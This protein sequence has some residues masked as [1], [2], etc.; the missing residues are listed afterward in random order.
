M[1]IFNVEIANQYLL[2]Q[3]QQWKQLRESELREIRS[4]LIKTKERCQ[5]HRSGVFVVNFER[6][7]HIVLL[8]YETLMSIN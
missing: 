4:K 8:F 3:S 7:S 2:V 1:R 6:V 5:S